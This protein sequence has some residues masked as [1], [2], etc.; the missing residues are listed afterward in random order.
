MDW[1]YISGFFDADGSITYV[2]RHASDKNKSL[3]LSFHNNEIEIIEEMRKFIKDE[4]GFKGTV[5][6]K[7]PQKS[8]HSLQYELK[9]MY[10]QALEVIKNIESLHPKKRHRISI[11]FKIQES[12]NR[13][14]KYTDSERLKREQLVHYFFNPN[15]NNNNVREIKI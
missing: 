14:G 7:K 4:L 6:T 12:T 13:N 2:K 5:S 15:K 1:Y 8:S 11:S 3:Q 10:R 9:Y